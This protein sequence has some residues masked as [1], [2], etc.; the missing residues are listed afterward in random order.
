LIFSTTTEYNS[1]NSLEERNAQWNR[2]KQ[3]EEK[4]RN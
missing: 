2:T 1:L 3:R 4:N